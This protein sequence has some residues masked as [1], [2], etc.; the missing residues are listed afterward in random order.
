MNDPRI[1]IVGAGPAGLA[2]A[3]HLAALDSTFI[4]RTLI[5]EAKAHPRPKLCGGGV[6]VHGEEQLERLGININVP[7]FEVHRLV[8]KLGLLDFKVP[9]R[10][11]MR[12][13]QRSEF[14][15]AIADA[16]IAKGF[17]LHTHERLREIHE[18]AHGGM[19]VVTDKATYHPMIVVGADGANS[20]VRRKL[21][22]AS[23]ESTARLL[24]VLT[25]IDTD[26]NP[27]WQAQQAV[28]DF[29]CVQQ[30]IQGY[31]WDFPCLVDGVP[32][33][34]AGIFDSHI[35]PDAR[36][37]QPHGNL[38]QTFADWLAQ[39]DVHI[40]SKDVV[41]RGHPVRWFN[42]Q[43]E[44]SRPHV[45]LTG[46]AAGVDALFAEGISY[47]MEYGAIAAQAIHHACKNG[48]FSFADYRAN[49]VNSRMGTL[50]ARRAWIARWLYTY[51][52]PPFWDIF[53]RFAN[54]AP[55]WMQRRI[56]AYMALLPAPG[57]KTDIVGDDLRVVP[58]KM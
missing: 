24:R 33:M 51:R 30:G 38:K 35:N 31:M 5:I 42:P 56:G 21:N 11:A 14:D 48:D 32:H 34:N 1:L 55:R 15:T 47:A 6:T 46:D 25:P 41:L 58:Q 44:F 8:F 12:V 3:L 28:F 37:D 36:R 17:T 50:L 43:S 52:L 22:F 23:S 40:D 16:V 13:I 2:L 57:L 18:N 20:T 26:S 19:T 9:H 53:W 29:S 45:L 49:L 7:A 4:E 54:I 10:H 27:S 39:R